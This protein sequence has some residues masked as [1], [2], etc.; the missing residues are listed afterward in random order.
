MVLNLISVHT[1][2]SSAVE[3]VMGSKESKFVAI[4]FSRG[5]IQRKVPPLVSTSKAMAYA[6]KSFNL[7]LLDYL[8]NVSLSKD[9]KSGRS[10]NIGICLRT[11]YNTY[12]MFWLV[13]DTDITVEELLYLD[14]LFKECDVAL[15]ISDAIPPLPLEGRTYVI[16]G[17]NFVIPSDKRPAAISI[18]SNS[19]IDREHNYKEITTPQCES[20]IRA[21]LGGRTTFRGSEL[22]VLF[23]VLGATIVRKTVDPSPADEEQLTLVRMKGDAST[24]TVH[25]LI[26]HHICG[27]TRKDLLLKLFRPFYTKCDVSLL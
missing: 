21:L 13:V 17:Q 25:E 7:C 14:E 26:H 16:G 2:A 11:Q 9:N 12:S 6:V 1:Q 18:G 27:Y 22:A 5:F 3:L 20:M 8:I 15:A 23:S 10:A 19:G 24:I 4:P